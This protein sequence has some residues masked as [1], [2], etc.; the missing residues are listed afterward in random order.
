MG[1]GLKIGI[2]AKFFPRKS[3]MS[4]KILG[5]ARGNQGKSLSMPLKVF[6]QI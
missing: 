5:I 4:R 2:T 3:I 1:E 6:Y